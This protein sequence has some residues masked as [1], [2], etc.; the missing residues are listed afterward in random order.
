M[1]TRTLLPSLRTTLRSR[2]LSTASDQLPD[3]ADVV[4]IGG[5]SIGTSTLLHLQQMGHNAILLERHQLTAGTTW[6]SAGM[7]WRLRPSDVD[8]ELHA[9]T[10]DLIQR[11]EIETDTSAWTENGGLFIAS[12]KERMKEYERLA[13]TGKYFGI[14]SQ[15]CSPEETRDIH[16]LVATDDVYASLYSPGDGTIDPTG[17][18]VAYSK[19]AKKLGGRIYEN[20]GVSNVVTETIGGVGGDVKHVRAVVTDSGHTIK[21][22]WVVNACGAWSNEISNSVGTALPLLAMKH[23]FVVTES[24]PGMHAKLPNV[25]DHDLSIYLKTQ[26]D[27]MAIGGYENNPEFWHNPTKDFSFGLFDLDWDTFGQN[28]EGHMKRCPSIETV[29]IKSTVC[30]PESFT[31]DHKPLVGP[32]PGVR[33]LFQ[34]CGF[35]SMGMMLGGGM[36]RE[37]AH[38]ITQGTPSLDLFSFDVARYHPDTSANKKWVFDRTHESYAKTYAIVFPHDE[39]LAGRNARTS[40]LHERLQQNGCI[41]QARHGFERPGWFVNVNN[42]EEHALQ[43]PKE[44]DYYGAYS[45]GAWRLS[46]E[47]EDVEG[48][49]DHL[50]NDLIEGELT[51][52]WPTSLEAVGK[53]CRAA[54]EGVAMFDQSYFGKFMLSGS[55]ADEAVRWLCGADVTQGEIGRVTYTPMCNQKG[56]VEADLTVTKLLLHNNDDDDDD[57]EQQQQQHQQHQYYFAAGGNTATKD[58]EWIVTALEQKGYTSEEVVLQDL[59][60]DLCILSIQGPHAQKFLQSKSSSL[61]SSLEEDN[62]DLSNDEF[63]PFSTAHT[64]LLLNGIPV[65]LA[66]RLTFVGEVGYE[67]HI[68]KEYAVQVY[69]A[70]RASGDIY[71]KEHSVPV[72]DAGYRAIDSLSA[73]KGYRHWHADLSNRD[74]P[75]EAGIGFTVL[76]R[77][78]R[79]DAAA[80]AAGGDDDDDFLGRAA[81]EE[82]RSIGLTRKLICLVLEDKDRALHGQETLWRDGICVGYVRSTAF[83]HTL[84]KTVVYGYVEKKEEEEANSTSKK[85]TNKWLKAGTWEIGDRG[86]RFAAEL[87]LKAPFDPTNARI[88][89]EYN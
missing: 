38:W 35:N 9:Y 32:Q 48:H 67:L 36:G 31:P 62:F 37:I 4:V 58:W 49:A 16:P 81:L 80:A 76:P 25:R 54:R 55:K 64:D 30:G 11:L 53:E 41:H 24:I 70:L 21:T 56:G 34:A 42:N 12:N 17:V 29:G 86:K 77:L 73:E 3:T 46:P 5:G 75:M 82:H 88:R 20:V 52:D 6:H 66:L 1:Q 84:G 51:F 14:E 23:A 8:I 60:D 47:Q 39:S 26:G 69:D 40:P 65:K 45:T 7:L 74:T 2:L 33:G 43:A 28:L 61:L 13:E 79:I 15:V 50:Y 57:A 18:V 68:Q 27:A 44:Y 78:K 87:H 59:S 63:F 89:G 22:P 72:L 10:R 71:E 19:A 83:G 85:V